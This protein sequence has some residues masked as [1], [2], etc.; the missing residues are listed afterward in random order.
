[1]TDDICTNERARA[2][3]TSGA[4]IDL[5][6]ERY[7]AGDDAAFALLYDSLAPR[8]LGYLA[9]RTRDRADAEDILQ[10]TM[11]HVHRSREAFIPGSEVA[12]WAFA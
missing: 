1:M 2:A 3:E 11:L 10:Q 7:A 4:V 6:M 5:A 8:I 9:R 12:P